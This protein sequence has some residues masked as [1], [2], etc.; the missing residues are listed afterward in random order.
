[1]AIIPEQQ[2]DERPF[3][4]GGVL[5]TVSFLWLLLLGAQLPSRSCRII[6][7]QRSN[8]NSSTARGVRYR[9]PLRVPMAGEMH[10][11]Y[12]AWVRRNAGIIASLEGA[13]QSAVWFLPDRFSD[14]ELKCEAL[15]AALGLVSI[16]HA[17]IIEEDK[18]L[19]GLLRKTMARQTIAKAA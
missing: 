12:K 13:A 6:I 15:N 8:S 10:E 16:Y 3:T 4:P 7:E 9:L 1:M 14:S 17:S 19:P 2:V 11:A 5:T 18:A